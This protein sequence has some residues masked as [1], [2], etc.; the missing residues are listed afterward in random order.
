MSG[1]GQKD[2]RDEECGN[3][4]RVAMAPL[5]CGGLSPL[6]FLATEN[7]AAPFL[8]PGVCCRQRVGLV[9]ERIKEA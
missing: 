2:K 9:R 1:I 3:A 7:R 5:D 4:Y 6:S 8:S